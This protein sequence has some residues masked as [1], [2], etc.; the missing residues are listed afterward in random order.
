MVRRTWWLR[1]L[2]STWD[3][4]L[5]HLSPLLS[6]YTI[7]PPG[8]SM[9]HLTSDCFYLASLK[10]ILHTPKNMSFLDHLSVSVILWL[11]TLLYLPYLNTVHNIAQKDSA[12]SHLK[13]RSSKTLPPPITAVTSQQSFSHYKELC[14][15]ISLSWTLESHSCKKKKEHGLVKQ[16]FQL[17]NHVAF[18]KNLL[19]LSPFYHLSLWKGHITDF[20]TDLL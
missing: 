18:E 2:S 15:T 17:N 8:L 5:C 9:V 12:W 19:N 11:K 13:L 20:F 1:E 4:H 10:T 16:I 3:G 7:A 14:W 6:S